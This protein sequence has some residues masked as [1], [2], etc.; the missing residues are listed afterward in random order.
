MDITSHMFCYVI[1]ISILGNDFFL[2]SLGLQST[3]N[4][5]LF[6]YVFCF[7]C[8]YHKNHTLFHFSSHEYRSVLF[9]PINWQIYLSLLRSSYDSIRMNS[10]RVLVASMNPLLFHVFSVLILRMQVKI[11]SQPIQPYSC[12]SHY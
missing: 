7:M 11:M 1:Y 9:I 3:A 10:L 4:M 2:R 12:M 8:T 6:R 5:T